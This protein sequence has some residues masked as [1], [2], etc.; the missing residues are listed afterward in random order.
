[1][2]KRYC[3]RCGKYIQD[4]QNY[5]RISVDETRSVP[6]ML[7]TDQMPNKDYCKE[8]MDEVIKFLKRRDDL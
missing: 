2:L 6:Y 1:M 8:C 3:D 7:Y 4:Y 5:Y